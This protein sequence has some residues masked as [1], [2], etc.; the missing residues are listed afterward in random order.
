MIVGRRLK[1]AGQTRGGEEEQQPGAW[2]H[3]EREG[4]H[5]V[6][7]EP[8]NAAARA[9]G[10]RISGSQ[11]QISKRFAKSVTIL[12]IYIFNRSSAPVSV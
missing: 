4:K 5:N 12:Y 3:G 7:L 8:G 1:G 10:G 2:G 9:Q 6:V 11:D